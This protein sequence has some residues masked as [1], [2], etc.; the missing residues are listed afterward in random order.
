MTS[1]VRG[2]EELPRGAWALVT[3]VELCS[4][5]RGHEYQHHFTITVYHRR[6]DLYGVRNRGRTLT[7]DGEWTWNPNTDGAGM[8]GY[9][10]A[11][12]RA[13]ALLP[14]LRLFDMTAEEALVKHDEWLAEREGLAR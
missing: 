4:V 14:G 1:P 12:T 5:P 13:C 8:W 6:D 7:P 3:E 9:D 10:E 11:F 2:A